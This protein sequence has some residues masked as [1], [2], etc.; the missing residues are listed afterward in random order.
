MSTPTLAQWQAGFKQY[1]FSG[2]NEAV[3]AGQVASSN[4]I[5]AIQ[6]LDIYRNAYYIRLQE[7]LAH[8]FPVLLAFMGEGDFGREMAAYIKACPSTS[9]SLRYIGK[10]LPDYLS[11][12]GKPQLADLARLEWA[13]LKAFDAAD[14]DILTVNDMAHIPAG[15]W[16]CLHLELHPSVS[17]L[18]VSRHVV[19]VWMA[20]HRERP[21]PVQHNDETVALLVWRGVNGPGLHK[22]SSECRLLIADLDEGLSFAQACER[23]AC[24]ML[25]DDVAQTAARCLLELL[26][27]GC[28]SRLG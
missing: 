5:N 1:L 9:P 26:Q 24:H 19:D 6:R 22:L 25:P 8:D 21:L 7:A 16:Q 3:F 18:E 2:A 13:V 15:S 14:A 10:R 20:H 27:G 28:F 17:L 11:R 4:A 23:L 12:Q